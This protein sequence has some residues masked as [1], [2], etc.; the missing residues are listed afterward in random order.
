[1]SRDWFAYRMEVRKRLGLF[2]SLLLLIPMLLAAQDPARQVP[3]NL[4]EAVID[5]FTTQRLGSYSGAPLFFPNLDAE[6]SGQ[7]LTV[8]GGQLVNG[9]ATGGLQN[10]YFWNKDYMAPTC[11][12]PDG[13]CYLR[14]RLQSGTWSTGYNRMS[15]RWRCDNAIGGNNTGTQYHLGTYARDGAYT[16]Q[17]DQ[18]SNGWHFYH[19]IHANSSP[20]RWVWVTVNTHTQHMRANTA[21]ADQALPANVTMPTGNY[22]DLFT[23][24]YFDR[25]YTSFAGSTCYFDDWTLG[26]QGSEPDYH[27]STLTYQYTGNHYEVAWQ[28]G[29]VDEATTY[30]VRYSTTGSL[31]TAGFAAG[32]DAG[33]VASAGA[34]GRTVYWISANMAE[35]ASGLWVGIRPRM[36]VQTASAAA[37]VAVGM[38]QHGLTTG[39]QVY[40]SGLGVTAA[41]N[42]T[43][44]VTDANTVTL[45]STTGSGN[46]G[47]GGYC[48]ATSNTA[49]F[50]EIFIPLAPLSAPGWP[51]GVTFSGTTTTATTVGFTPEYSATSTTV[52]RRIIGSS[53][54]VAG[55]T[56]TGSFADSGLNP[57]TKYQYRFKSSNATGAGNYSDTHVSHVYPA[58]TTAI[59]S[60][61]P[62]FTTTTL[63]DPNV[64]TVYSRTLAATGGT[65]PYSF[66]LDAGILPAGLTLSSAGAITGTPTT[67]AALPGMAVT[68]KVTDA[69]SRSGYLGMYLPVN[70]LPAT[71]N[72]NRAD[73]WVGGEWSNFM[74]YGMKTYAN[75]LK[76]VGKSGHLR[77]KEWF[78]SDQW[79]EAK[80]TAIG[81]AGF[82][83]PG[84][85]ASS[86]LGGYFCFQSATQLCL[87]RWQQGGY[88]VT[89]TCADSPFVA[90]TVVR[91][92]AFDSTIRCLSDGTVKAS[93]TNADIAS[94]VPGVAGVG[95]EGTLMDDWSAGNISTPVITTETL[96]DAVVGYS[97]SATFAAVR[98]VEPFVW[99]VASGSLPAG[100]ALSSAG[101]LS[102]TPTTAGT[103]SFP[104]RAVDSE[105]TASEDKTL[106]LM[107]LASVPPLSVTTDALTEGRTAIAYTHA[108][109]ATGGLTPYT[110]SLAS[111][112]LPVGLSLSTTGVISGT[113]HSAGSVN[114]TVRVTDRLAETANKTLTLAVI[115]TVSATDDFNRANEGLGG[116][117]GWLNLL[118][119]ESFFVVT[120]TAKAYDAGVSNAY[121]VSG[122]AYGNLSP[123]SDQY[124]IVKWKALSAGPAVRLTTS[125]ASGYGCMPLDG[126]LGIYSFASAWG[127]DPV[128]I[129][130]P[131]T[132]VV[133]DEIKLSVTGH[134]LR[135]Y[136]NGVEMLAVTNSRYAIGYT[137][138]IGKFNGVVD[139]W[140][141]GNLALQSSPSVRSRPGRRVSQ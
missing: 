9:A 81:G 129:E 45:D 16:N 2:L 19:E 44:T 140:E 136:V 20:W 141:G 7:T 78:S 122:H 18:E 131:Y 11:I 52:E 62:R 70:Q 100:L 32:T 34:G 98:G 133:D 101:V 121:K 47:G 118:A 89:K 36:P 90:N 88:E 95:D 117:H 109:A 106:T 103:V 71:D 14:N 124:A 35:N 114:I 6:H 30:E 12:W 113:T 60:T 73:D 64:G 139:D 53:W 4:R 56:A 79:A 83:G 138:I 116:N 63:P 69:N 38:F 15:F 17:N 61:Y 68:F 128:L 13:S 21:A 66:T 76:P 31:K 3:P 43:A 77:T 93:I 67:F 112:S 137:G 85:R 42:Y 97:Y 82:I 126:K 51:L 130:T 84:V 22:F 27:V 125:P 54:V 127:W 111:G 57:G 41:G 123:A 87:T 65:A 25:K 92:E 135:C 28:A 74:F 58:V 102:G 107:T 119:A 105:G 49:N 26:T 59:D 91:A 132:P 96:L 86:A 55:T 104:V 94:G 8:A 46:Y 23:S 80:I 75:Q 24:F 33:T 5:D 1:M 99:S 110:W 29:R 48:K 40:C 10:M 108:L 120:N 72:F 50:T 115:A 37:P 134:T 39:D